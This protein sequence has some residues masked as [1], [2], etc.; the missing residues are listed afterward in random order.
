MGKGQRKHIHF[1]DI[2]FCAHLYAPFWAQENVYPPF[3]NS[4]V[5]N[6]EDYCNVTVMYF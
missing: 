4:Y 6:S 5:I 3:V 1:L 2:N